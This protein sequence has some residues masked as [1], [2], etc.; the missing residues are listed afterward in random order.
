MAT[1]H[2]N[3]IP[4]PPV[5]VIMGHIDHGKSTLLD[6]IRTS[7]IAST[8]AGGIT[9][10]MSAYEVVH[11]TSDGEKRIT[12][13]DTPGHE[14][15]GAM[16]SRGANV[17]DIAVLVVSVED[18]VK[19]QTLEALKSIEAANIPYIVALNKI[20]RPDANIEWA[21]QNLAENGIYVEGYGGTISLVPISAI[22]GQGVPELLDMMLLVADMEDLKGDPNADASGIVIESNLDKK[23]GISAT[24]I[25]KNGTLKSG[26]YVI[27]G[28]SHSPVRIMEDF[29]GKNIREATFSSPVRII[30]WSELPITGAEF[31]VAKNKKEAESLAVEAKTALETD[32]VQPETNDDTVMI[33]VVAKVGVAGVLDALMHELKKIETDTV[34][35][36]LIQKGVGDISEKDV[37]TA[38]GTPDTLVV[39][40]NVNVDSTAQ[41]YAERNNVKIATF[42]IIYKL[43]EW[44]QERIVERTPKKEVEETKGTAK[45]LR[46][47]S[48]ARDKQVIG[49]KVLDG[50]VR[51][52]SP[53]KIIRRESEIGRG[54]VREL[55][56]LKNR[57]SDVGEGREFGAMIECRSMIAEGDKIECY[58]VTTV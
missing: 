43:S 44:L 42:D 58:E 15:F 24:L 18:G 48:Q 23:K 3:T 13:L 16:R 53:V 31:T 49:G 22:T 56:H 4:R 29:L 20:D 27:A 39:G 14:A 10:A 2:T 50:T 30:G 36:K 34:K 11:T 19:P 54:R 52:G 55:Q 41:N 12:F 35:L 32:A 25:I 1:Q 47:F 33:P 5:I 17:A 37:K 40:F 6:Y 8:E 51:V 9:Q 45:V 46:V 28:T 38:L 57:V 7:N 26:S 21:K